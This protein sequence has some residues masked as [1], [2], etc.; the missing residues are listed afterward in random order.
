MYKSSCFLS[1]LPVTICTTRRLGSHTH[2]TNSYYRYYSH[3]PSPALIHAEHSA[4]RG[5]LTPG[6]LSEGLGEVGEGRAVVR[7]A[8]P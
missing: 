8:E 5:G 4:A 7:G 1:L 3:L 2:W 6:L